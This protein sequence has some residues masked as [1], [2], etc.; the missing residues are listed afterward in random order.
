M[1]LSPVLSSSDGMWEIKGVSASNPNATAPLG[2]Q[3]YQAGAAHWVGFDDRFAEPVVVRAYYDPLA[4]PVYGRLTQVRPFDYVGYFQ[5]MRV[6]FFDV[7]VPPAVYGGRLADRQ[8]Y[9]YGERFQFIDFMG[10][11]DANRYNVQIPAYPCNAYLSRGAT[12][13]AADL[14][15]QPLPNGSLYSPADQRPDRSLAASLACEVAPGLILPANIERYLSADLSDPSLIG[16]YRVTAAELGSTE[17]YRFALNQLEAPT[18]AQDPETLNGLDESQVVA[19]VIGDYVLLTLPDPDEDFGPTLCVS[20]RPV[21]GATDIRVHL[22]SPYDTAG[23][24]A[25][26]AKNA[27]R[28]VDAYATASGLLLGHGR[29]QVAPPGN[30]GRG[31]LEP[32]PY[33]IDPAEYPVK[34][35]YSTFAAGIRTPAGQPWSGEFLSGFAWTARSQYDDDLGLMTLSAIDEPSPLAAFELT[36]A[37]RQYQAA[38]SSPQTSSARIDPGHFTKTTM[39]RDGFGAATRLTY[40][41]DQP[42]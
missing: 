6:T 42:N 37:L 26:A 33:D 17:P 39:R 11:A 30:R 23:M 40:I 2:R 22:L 4:D 8:P 21:T 15:L 29:A 12:L 16:R 3:R 41:P 18:P 1:S 27:L 5:V 10:P 32:V 7:P 14:A 9:A 34:V 35:H 38:L 36:P 25:D 13:S 28:R 19:E 24:R 31:E 20:T